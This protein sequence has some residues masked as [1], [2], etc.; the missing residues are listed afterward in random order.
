[1][2]WY[3]IFYDLYILVTFYLFFPLPPL[4]IPVPVR[5]ISFS[6]SKIGQISDPILPF[7]TLFN[8]KFPDRKYGAEFSKIKWNCMKIVFLREYK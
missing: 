1:M 2:L 4:D 3:W 7:I 6:H 8:D 5:P